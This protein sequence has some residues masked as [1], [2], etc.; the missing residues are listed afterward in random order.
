MLST[1]T[2][3]DILICSRKLNIHLQQQQN[4]VLPNNFPS[5][6]VHYSSA[7]FCCCCLFV[8]K[9]GILITALLI[10]FKSLSYWKLLLI[11]LWLAQTNMT[12]CSWGRL[13]SMFVC[14]RARGCV[15]IYSIDER[16]LCVP[17]AAVW[18]LQWGTYNTIQY[19]TTVLPSVNTIALG[20]FC[21]FKW[22]HHIFT[23]IIKHH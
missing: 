13:S 9:R 22:T 21:G 3:N 19:N 4:T 11:S 17:S 15:L 16:L 20:M 23:P 12:V 14:L 2:E 7:A 18:L 1:D 6:T 8:C 5:C 10:F